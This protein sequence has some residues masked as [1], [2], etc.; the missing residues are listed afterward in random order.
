M[1]LWERALL[2]V[3]P[4]DRIAADVDS[5]LNPR[6][7]NLLGST[8]LEGQQQPFSFGLAPVCKSNII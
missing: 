4:P 1:E 7:E 5:N 3:K 6:P 8:Y 2:N